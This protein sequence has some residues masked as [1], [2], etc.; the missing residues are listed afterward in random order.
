VPGLLPI[1][2]RTHQNISRNCTVTGSVSPFEDI[3]FAHF[4]EHHQLDF[5]HVQLEYTFV[6]PNFLSDEELNMSKEE[7][8]IAAEAYMLENL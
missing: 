8:Q 1:V 7:A 4:C 5:K 3:W 2:T 6:E